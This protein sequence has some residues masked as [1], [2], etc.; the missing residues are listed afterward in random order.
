MAFKIVFLLLCATIL[1][2]CVSSQTTLNTKQGTL[3]GVSVQTPY[4]GARIFYGIP[5]ATPPVGDLRLR[6]PK[7][8][9]GFQEYNATYNRAKCMQHGF[10]SHEADMLGF[11]NSMN[12][13]EDCL[14]LNVYVPDNAAAGMAVMV[15]I[16]GGGYNSGSGSLYDARYIATQ[17]GVIVVT[18]NY[19]LGLLGF[20][21][22]GG[23]EETLG[24]QDQIMA[25]SWVQQAIGAFGGDPTRV[26]IF[27][28]SAGSQSVSFLTTAPQARGLFTRAIMESGVATS[29][30]DNSNHVEQMYTL[31]AK[32]MELGC[33]NDSVTCARNFSMDQLMKLAP[34][35]PNPMPGIDNDVIPADFATNISLV[36]PGLELII[37][38]NQNEGSMGVYIECTAMRTQICDVNGGVDLAQ[39]QAMNPN[40]TPRLQ[41][42]QMNILVQTYNNWFPYPVQQGRMNVR[43]ASQF[44]GDWVFRIPSN[45]TATRLVEAGFK[46]YVYQ[47][48]ATTHLLPVPW[49]SDAQHA[50]EIPFVFGWVFQSP[51]EKALSNGMVKLWT[52]FAKG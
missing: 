31:N 50:D 25:L 29:P 6:P 52:D 30:F 32:V 2:V 51:Q 47:F 8:P 3:H 21:P 5:Y 10:F 28:E 46:V 23:T 17:G 13:N 4:G 18:I 16:H 38:V 7:P 49:S 24:L 34:L 39:R 45:K 35:A 44:S 1:P 15:W 27:G 33:F 14:Y 42:D 41:P 12:M 26:T 48:N 43:A 37:G 36:H 9:A 40:I 11:N 19:R 20:F 22:S